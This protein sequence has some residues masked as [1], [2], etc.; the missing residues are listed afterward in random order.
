MKTSLT[1]AEI[2]KVY[3]KETQELYEKHINGNSQNKAQ[4]IN[5]MTFRVDYLIGRP[6]SEFVFDI[7]AKYSIWHRRIHNIKPTQK[8]L[9]EAKENLKRIKEGN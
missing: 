2:I 8:A 3:P 9:N 1:S 4:N 5:D 6:Y 7:G